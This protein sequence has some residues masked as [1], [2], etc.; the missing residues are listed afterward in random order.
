M[1]TLLTIV[2]DYSLLMVVNDDSSLT[3]VNEIEESHN[4]LTSC[5]TTFNNVA[6]KF[7]FKSDRFSKNDHFDKIRRFDN[8]LLTIVFQKRSFKKKQLYIRRSQ[9]VF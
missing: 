5:T 3:I 1:L 2:N 7:F 9:I 6:C 8:P 4:F